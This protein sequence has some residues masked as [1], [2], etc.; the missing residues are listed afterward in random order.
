MCLPVQIFFTPVAPFVSLE[1]GLFFFMCSA[2]SVPPMSGKR[3][4]PKSMG[5]ARASQVLTVVAERVSQSKS[6]A[7]IAS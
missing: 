6:L 1:C 4:A 7:R 2:G 5:A 3:A